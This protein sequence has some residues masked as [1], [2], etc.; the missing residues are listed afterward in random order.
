MPTT[1][2]A[3]RRRRDDRAPAEST[4]RTMTTPLHAANAPHTHAHGTSHACSSS[5]CYFHGFVGRRGRRYH[6]CAAGARHATTSI[7]E[8]QRTF[9]VT[10]NNYLYHARRHGLSSPAQT[11][12]HARHLPRITVT[13]IM[14][15]RR[16]AY[17]ARRRLSPGTPSTP[18]THPPP[19]NYA[20][21][22]ITHHCFTHHHAHSRPLTSVPF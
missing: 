9:H 22:T 17:Y 18:I 21:P 6:V 2:Q 16:T 20:T 7:A 5:F 15:A 11:S 19:N 3:T 10:T 4:P 8:T 1:F 13:P 12:F 14:T